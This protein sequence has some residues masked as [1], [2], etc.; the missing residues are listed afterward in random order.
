META[1]RVID[2]SKTPIENIR[3]IQKAIAYNWKD[4][5][6]GTGYEIAEGTGLGFYESK[7]FYGA[8]AFPGASGWF[9]DWYRM[10]EGG[11]AWI[12]FGYPQKVFRT[13]WIFST[14]AAW[15]RDLKFFGG[16]W[17]F[18]YLKQFTISNSVAGLIR[19]FA[20]HGSF[21]FNLEIDWQVFDLLFGD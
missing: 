6:I 16:N 12:K 20:K 2:S 18:A 7:V 13:L 5:W 9:F 21:Y 19:N 17:V 14:K 3:T 1:M 10:P 11:N 15:N 8:S 4:F